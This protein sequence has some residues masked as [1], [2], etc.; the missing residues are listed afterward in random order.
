MSVAEQ[1]EALRAATERSL[2]IRRTPSARDALIVRLYSEEGKSLRDVS[3]HA[4]CCIE[5]AR[6]VL[7]R[8]GVKLRPVGL[9][10]SRFPQH[11][12]QER[13]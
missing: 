2:L 12:P 13:L 9:N 1:I 10:Y 7:N 5:T 11:F 8:N 4:G 6:N 3:E